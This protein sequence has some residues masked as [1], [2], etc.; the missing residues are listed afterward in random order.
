MTRD[1][2]A[3]RT[4]RAEETPIGYVPAPGALDTD[5]INVTPTQLREA[6][7]CDAGE[8]LAALDDLGQFFDGFGS[9]LPAPIA[10]SLAETRRKFGA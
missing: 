8:W 7:R 3:R 5:G 2:P 1:I 6:L 4:G 10:A 9:R